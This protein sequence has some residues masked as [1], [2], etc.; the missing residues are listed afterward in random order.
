[1]CIGHEDYNLNLAGVLKDTI[2][3]RFSANFNQRITG[4]AQVELRLYQTCRETLATFLTSLPKG[5]KYRYN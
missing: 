2:D 3:C 4:S 5:V 1:M